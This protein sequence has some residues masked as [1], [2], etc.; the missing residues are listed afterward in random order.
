MMQAIF[1]G[2]GTCHPQNNAQTVVWALSLLKAG[3]KNL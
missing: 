3:Y 1:F 2:L